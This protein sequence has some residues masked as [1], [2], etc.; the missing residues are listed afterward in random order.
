[1]AVI[2]DKTIGT[3]YTAVLSATDAINRPPLLWN[4]AD[5]T[6]TLRFGG[7][8]DTY[9]LAAG[10]GL[11]VPASTQVDALCASGSKTLQIIRAA[12]PGA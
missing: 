8:G 7:A 4:A 1:M 9:D 11:R 5:E 10:K 2:E 3:D 6:M 12:K